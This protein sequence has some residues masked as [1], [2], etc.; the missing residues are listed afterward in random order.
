MYDEGQAKLDA[1][2]KVARIALWVF[3]AVNVLT[4]IGEVLEATGTINLDTDISPLVMA[5]ALTYVSYSL[6][7][8]VCVVIVAMWIHRAH[9]NLREAG[10]DG[11]EFTPGWAVG[12]YFIPFANLF[13][14]YQAMREL[15]NASHSEDNSFASE[16][17]SEVKVW[18]GCWI[19]GNILSSVSSRIILMGEGDPSSVAIGS[20]LGLISDV[21]IILAALY[22][23]KI[24]EQVT[25]AQRAGGAAA[26]VFA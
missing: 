26:G 1:R 17:P 5:V 12:W 18:W 2:A 8:I 10:V 15:W 19:V 25:Q 6:V 22:L 11:L 16:A 13:K 20:T 21:P 4:A 9:T 14:P 23:M 3:V 24:V 7:F